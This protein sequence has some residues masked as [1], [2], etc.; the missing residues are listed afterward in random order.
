M[1]TDEDNEHH[2]SKPHL[3]E[4]EHVPYVGLKVKL[5]KS[6]E[7]FYNLANDRRSIRK[8]NKNKT[9]DISV[10]EKCILAAGLL[11]NFRFK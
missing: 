9:V 2:T 4:R 1:D 7:I 5:D 8:F 6:G 10:I 11:A 3:T